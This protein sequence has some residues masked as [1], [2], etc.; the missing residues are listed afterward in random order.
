MKILFVTYDFPYPLTSGGKNR[1][2]H[3]LNY[4]SNHEIFLFSFTR[5]EISEKDKEEVQNIG[6][7][8]IRLFKR[9]KV[10]NFK[11][12]SVLFSKNSIF[13]TLYYNSII[14]KELL[15]FIQNKKIDIVVFESFYTGFYISEKIS[16]LGVRQI[17]GTENL[18]YKIYSDYVLW[19]VPFFL[20][21]LFQ[22]TVKNIK[23]E[24]EYMLK[25]SDVNIA[26]TKDEKEYIEKISSKPC[27]VIPNGVDLEKFKFHKRDGKGKN[28][29]FV[30]DFSYF[31]NVDAITYFYKE[32]FLQMPDSDLSLSIIGKNIEKLSFLTD[33]RIHAYSYVSDIVP[34]YKNADIFI[35]PVR[36][37]GGTN[38]KVIEAMATGLP[39]VADSARLKGLGVKNGEDIL[40]ADSPA[41]FKNKIE[42]LFASNSLREKLAKNA[43]K[44]VEENFS[45]EEIGK[46]LQ[47]VYKV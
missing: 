22:N 41:A 14:E 39:V 33:T 35:S 10:F 16:N 4:S 5:H 30:G 21:F 31:P 11:N 3:L 15:S 13:K 36:I 24:E 42:E 20:R 37:G 38:F 23:T 1:A 26:V 2:F 25:N 8:E 28:L 12:A 7:K 44:L 9:R 18:E 32:V 17:F 43:R 47:E 34:M 40:F 46:K 27:V 6:V 45:W 29:L 19:K